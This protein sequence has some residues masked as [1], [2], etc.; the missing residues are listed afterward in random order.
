MNVNKEKKQARAPKPLEAV[1]ILIV[2]IAVIVVCIKMQVGA[3]MALMV[4]TLIAALA[5]LAFHNP[6]SEIQ[7]AMLKTIDDSMMAVLI[8]VLVGIMIGAWMIGGTVPSIMYYGLMF[9]TPSLILPLS[10]VLCALMSVFTGTSFGSI[11][12]MGLALTGVAAGMGMP[13]PIVVGAVISGC[14]FG[15]KLSPMSDNTNMA[16]A[17]TGVGL[18]DHIGGMM[19][20]AIP[21]TVVSLIL[22]T[23]IGFKY[24]SGVMDDTNI[25]LMMDTLNAQF[26]I[27]PI[28]VIPAILMLVVSAKKVP[29]LLGLGGCA[30]FSIVFAAMIQNVSVIEV[31]QV[32]FNGYVSEKGVALVDTI[33]SRGGMASMSGTIFLILAASLMGGAL[34]ASRIL[35]VLVN[36]LMKVVKKVFSLVFVT[37]LYSYFILL[38]SGN[39]VLPLV[40]AGLVFK[41]AYEDMGISLKVLS[42]SMSDSATVAAP[43]VPWGTSCSYAM[44]VLGIGIEYI[45]FA[46]FCYIVPIFSLVFAALGIFVWKTGGTPQTETES[47]SP[48]EKS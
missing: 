43:L 5:A 14:Y 47:I 23:V 6:W 39:Q 40:M 37:M 42:R 32:A 8:L 9:C 35:E 48:A 29:S 20:T 38:L 15:D 1:L 21:A 46:F 33:L 36:M 10:F 34:K 45:P 25:I 19:P 16:S 4:G 18:Y 7:K 11:A 41:P 44:G 31:M 27:S 17:M 30:T 12:T 3:Q 22:Y 13:L 28:A 26:H 24:G 2:L